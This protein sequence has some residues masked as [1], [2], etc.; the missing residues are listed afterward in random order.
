MTPVANMAQSK[1]IENQRIDKFLFVSHIYV[2]YTLST[3]YVI[4]RKCKTMFST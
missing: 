2:A 1:N 4:L 3:K